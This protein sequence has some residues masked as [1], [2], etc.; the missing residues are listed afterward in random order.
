M[1][2]DLQVLVST[3]NLKNNDEVENLLKKMHISTNY[4]IINQN[5]DNAINMK[6][7]NVITRNE[8]G[9]TKSRNLAI[10][11]ANGDVILFADDDVIYNEDYKQIILNAYNKYK[12]ADIICFYIESR[13]K[14]RKIKKMKTGKIGYLKSLRIVS[15]EM[16]CKRKSLLENNLSFDENFGIGTKNNRGEEQIFL[17][18]ALKKRIKGNICQ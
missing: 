16:S 2:E 7:E 8:K 1:K 10:K 18:E 11:E 14:K 9:L 13:N 4:L 3:Q 5:M 15:V 17:Y 6:N 12:N